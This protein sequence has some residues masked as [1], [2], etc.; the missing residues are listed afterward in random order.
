MW[1]RNPNIFALSS[2]AWDY[3]KMI[4]VICHRI[5]KFCKL[6]KQFCSENESQNWFFFFELNLHLK[7]LPI[8]F[9]DEFFNI[10]IK[11]LLGPKLFKLFNRIICWDR[12]FILKIFPSVKLVLDLCWGP[13]VGCVQLLSDFI[14]LLNILGHDSDLLSIFKMIG[15]EF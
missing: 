14:L 5:F 4:K 1:Q 8:D 12:R 3:L 15:A 11:Y 6:E 7:W 2:R 13:G 9:S 10:Q